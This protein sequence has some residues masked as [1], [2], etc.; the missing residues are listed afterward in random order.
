MKYC[1]KEGGKQMKSKNAC[2]SRERERE[3]EP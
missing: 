1:L 3:R 2:G